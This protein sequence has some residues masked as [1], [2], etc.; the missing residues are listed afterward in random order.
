MSAISGFSFSRF[1]AVAVKEFIQMRRDRLTFAM[2]VGVPILQLVLF[3]FAINLDPKGLPTVIIQGDDSVHARSVVASLRTSGYLRII[4]SLPATTRSEDVLASGQAQFVITIPPQ[5][6]RD[7][8]RGDKPALLVQADASDP[9]ATGNA[10]SA[11][12]QLPSTALRNDLKGPLAQL[13]P[14][15]PPFEVRVHRLYNPEGITAYNIVPGL[16][17]TIMTMTMIMMTGMAIT[18]ERERG[19]MENLLS[20]PLKPIEILTGKIFPYIFV[21]YVQLGVILVAAHFLFKVPIEGSLLLLCLCA[22]AFIAANLSVGILFSTLA[23][24]QMQAMQM[25]FFFFLP[26]MLLSGFM[27]PFRGMPGWAQV[28]GEGL[29]LTHFLRVVRGIVL[30]GNELPQLWPHVWP[31]LAFAGVGLLLGALRFRRT[32]D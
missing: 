3:G 16:V 2:M 12:L 11:V 22:A 9:A 5:F 10:L 18:R 26:S 28:I 6:G 7:I 1:W 17:G 13:A 19:N 25:T 29:P 27:F 14:R 23:K 31:M 15:A 21:G 8:E 24:S 32:L 4:D 30:K 20:M